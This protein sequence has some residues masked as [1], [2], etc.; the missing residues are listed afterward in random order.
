MLKSISVPVPTPLHIASSDLSSAFAH[1]WQSIMAGPTLFQR[2]R[3][4]ALSLIPNSQTEQ[5]FCV[6]EFRFN[7]LRPGVGESIS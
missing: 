5:T 3:F 1:S 7:M 4:N 6:D 2:C